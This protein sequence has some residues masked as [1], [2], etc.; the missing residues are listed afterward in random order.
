MQRHLLEGGPGMRGVAEGRGL[1]LLVSVDAAAA[2][3]RGTI[4]CFLPAEQRISGEHAQGV[5][6]FLKEEKS[7]IRFC[8]LPL[9]TA[10]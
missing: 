7:K 6:L 8:C 5:V 3:R 10:S 1:K 9:H 4:F 2:E